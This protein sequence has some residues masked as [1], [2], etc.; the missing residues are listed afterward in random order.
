MTKEE[1]W[2]VEKKKNKDKKYENPQVYSEEE[3]KLLDGKKKKRK[4]AGKSCDTP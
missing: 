4:K 2:N 3:D 1:K